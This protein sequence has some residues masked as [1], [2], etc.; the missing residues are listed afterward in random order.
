[1]LQ[2]VILRSMKQAMY[3]VENKGHF[4]LAHT[5]YLHFTSPIRR[6]PDLLVHRSIKA[7]LHK[8]PI[9]EF[10]VE[11]RLVQ[12]EHCSMT[13]RR[14]EQASRECTSWLKCQYMVRHI[15]ETFTG[16][17]TGVMSFG[18][19]IGL[20]DNGIE[21][22]VHVSQLG[23]DYFEYDEVRQQMLG[24]RSRK[25]YRI[26]DAVTVTVARVSIH[27]R[28]IDFSLDDDTPPVTKPGRRSKSRRRR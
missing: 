26:G 1:M 21:G 20:D 14:A 8:D 2:T 10:L 19:F 9:D 5:E 23:N 4:G 28:Q 22:L 3:S 24:S 15:G 12:A 16:T 27:D 25:R 7:I 13:E 11:K 6:Y 18:L 17:V